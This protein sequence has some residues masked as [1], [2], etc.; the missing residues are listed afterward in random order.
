MYEFVCDGGESVTEYAA[1]EVGGGERGFS[2]G[3]VA[4]AG[5]MLGSMVA[6]LMKLLH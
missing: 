2:R 6:I 1:V 3:L 5:R 4:L